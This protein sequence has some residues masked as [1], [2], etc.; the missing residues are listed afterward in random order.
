MPEVIERIAAYLATGELPV[1]APL[2]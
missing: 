2:R 1:A